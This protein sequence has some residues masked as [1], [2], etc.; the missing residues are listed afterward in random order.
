MYGC[1]AEY[2][3]RLM[4]DA[5]YT[6]RA[7]RF[8]AL[9][10]T[11]GIPG[12]D[13]L[14][15]ACGTGSLLP[16]LAARGYSV[17]GVDQSEEMLMRAQ[18]K[19]AEA[20]ISP[21]LLCQDMRALNLYGTVDAAVCALDSLNHLPG[22]NAVDETLARLRLFVR[23][24]G[25]LLFDINSEYKHRCVLADNSFVLEDDTLFCVWQ[26]EFDSANSAVTVT[27]DFFESVDEDCYTRQTEQFTEYAYPL[28]LWQTLLEKNGFAVQT[29]YDDLTDKPAHAHS[30]R[31]LVAALRI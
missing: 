28:P 25:V 12:G 5:D 14:D 17:I 20:G 23:P 21:L 7:E 16:L 22:E 9:L 26:N 4:Q 10:D 13:V 8:C 3:D 24:G 18:E 27:L 2:Y 31:V 1:F 30:E 11:L 15:L 29:M 6:Q 19:C